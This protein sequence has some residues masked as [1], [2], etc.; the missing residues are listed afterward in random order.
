MHYYL[1]VFLENVELPKLLLAQ[2]NKLLITRVNSIGRD[3]FDQIHF[4]PEIKAINALVYNPLNNSVIISDNISKNI[5]EYKMG[6]N[7]F[8]VLVDSDL[9]DATLIDFGSFN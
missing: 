6:S 9:I 5:V 1:Y 3:T 7:D 8:T 4:P 2:Q